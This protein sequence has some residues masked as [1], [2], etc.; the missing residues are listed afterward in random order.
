[1]S[2][3]MFFVLNSNRHSVSKKVF[4]KKKKKILIFHK[5]NPISLA[6]LYTSWARSK[7][8]SMSAS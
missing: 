1:M 8:I 4:V 5:I 2:G 3:N 6:S 7:K